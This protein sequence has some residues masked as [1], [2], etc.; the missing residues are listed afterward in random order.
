MIGKR[1]FRP[2]GEAGFFRAKAL[3]YFQQ[4]DLE[5][6]RLI[7]TDRTFAALAIGELR[8]NKE[9]KFVAFIHELKTFGPSGND[10]V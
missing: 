4:F 8:R 3:S 5:N 6:Q 1:N 7:R 10:A 9:A 2:R